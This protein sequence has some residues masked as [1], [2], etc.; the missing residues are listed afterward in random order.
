GVALA[1]YPSAQDDLRPPAVT[2]VAE[3]DPAG[4]IAA[5]VLTAAPS[6][7]PILLTG[8]GG[9]PRVTEE[10]LDALG[11]PET[12]EVKAGSSPAAPAAA[13]PRLPDRRFGS[14]PA[15]LVLAPEDQLAFAMPAAAWA[16]RSGDPVLFTAK[17][18]LPA[19][20]ARLLRAHRKT[21]VYV[22]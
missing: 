15:H 22:L 13:V 2:L 7:A 8:E 20:T 9:P 10:A 16:A 6:R 14:P 11:D 21:P 4:A 5:A 17:D 18:G 12:T 3:S 19:P 1:V